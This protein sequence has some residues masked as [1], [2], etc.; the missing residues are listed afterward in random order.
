MKH[1]SKHI[2]LYSY[3]EDSVEILGG[4]CMKEQIICLF[5]SQL[6]KPR[7]PLGI[8]HEIPLPPPPHG[9][10]GGGRRGNTK[11]SYKYLTLQIKRKLHFM[12]WNSKMFILKLC[13]IQL[14]QGILKQ[15][16]IWKNSKDT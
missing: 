11:S 7:I 6:Y 2:F 13:K 16:L 1:I 3:T 12:L 5:I 14:G 4:W 10:R 9:A 8:Q 15:K